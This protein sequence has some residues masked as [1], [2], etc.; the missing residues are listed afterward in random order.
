MPQYHIGDSVEV[1][2]TMLEHT[3]GGGVELLNEPN[4]DTRWTTGIIEDI[5]ATPG[6]AGH[7]RYQVRLTGDVL[8][9][10]V[11]EVSAETLRQPAV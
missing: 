10:E 7:E 4:P 11:T 8:S 1:N 6:G 5:H 2:V 9:G 3:P